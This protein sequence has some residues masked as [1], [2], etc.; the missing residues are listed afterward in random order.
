MV[1]SMRSVCRQRKKVWSEGWAGA[2]GTSIQGSMLR[3]LELPCMARGGYEGF[4]TW[5]MQ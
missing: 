3:T 4:L 2:H 1:L 5:G